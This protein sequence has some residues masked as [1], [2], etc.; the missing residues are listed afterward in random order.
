MWNEEKNTLCP[1]KKTRKKKLTTILS[2]HFS[3]IYFITKS[4]RLWNL[5]VSLNKIFFLVIETS[6]RF[7]SSDKTYIKEDS[8]YITDKN[9]V[10]VIRPVWI[11]NSSSNGI[12]MRIFLQKYVSQI[13][14]EKL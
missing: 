4:F 2:M 1:H 10:E 11:S 5:M 9:S 7:K 6:K 13:L 8:C 3:S 14:H 12:E